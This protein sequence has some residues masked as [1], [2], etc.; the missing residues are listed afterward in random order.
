MTSEIDGKQREKEKQLTLVASEE[1][2]YKKL[3]TLRR[4][5][6]VQQLHIPKLKEGDHFKKI[7]R[8]ICYVEFKNSKN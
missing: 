7:T 6:K 8:V 1:K 4:M 3:R 2:T 5:K